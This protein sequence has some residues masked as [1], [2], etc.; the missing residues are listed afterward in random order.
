[1]QVRVENFVKVY[2]PHYTEELYV[3]PDFRDIEQ[4][5]NQEKKRN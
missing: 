2:T 4:Q 5:Q 1:M 3:L